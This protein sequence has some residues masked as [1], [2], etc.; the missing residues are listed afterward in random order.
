M[1]RKLGP[2]GCRNPISFFFLFSF[3][4]YVI[5][6]LSLSFSLSLMLMAPSERSLKVLNVTLNG[7]KLKNSESRRREEKSQ[8][9]KNKI[10]AIFP[11]GK[12][13]RS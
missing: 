4:L 13:V 1:I 3:F 10:Y 6:S 8:N 11:T 7:F 5:L 2:S 12:L 9:S